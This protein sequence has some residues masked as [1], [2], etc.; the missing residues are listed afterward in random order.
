MPQQRDG[1]GAHTARAQG[2]R[3]ATAGY[4][5]LPSDPRTHRPLSGSALGPGYVPIPT[6]ER[7]HTGDRF[8]TVEGLNDD[9]ATWLLYMCASPPRVKPRAPS[10]LLGL[11][12][13]RAAS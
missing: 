3:S 11:Q 7:Y 2:N 4:L 13:P 10:A 6:A 12:R 5:P 1:A 8:R 9:G